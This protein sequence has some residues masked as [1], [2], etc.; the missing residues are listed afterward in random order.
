MDLRIYIF[1]KQVPFR[2]FGVLVSFDANNPVGFL[3]MWKYLPLPKLLELC[4]IVYQ[5]WLGAG[6]HEQF[7]NLS[8]G[9]FHY[10]RVWNECKVCI[11]L[12]L[13]NT[14]HHPLLWELCTL[15][16]MYTSWH[17]CPCKNLIF[18]YRMKFD[19]TKWSCPWNS[20]KNSTQNS[21]DV[22]SRQM[23]SFDRPSCQETL[24]TSFDNSVMVRVWYKNK[25]NVK[26]DFIYKP[27]N[28][29]HLGYSGSH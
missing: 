18:V 19:K 27:R 14:F 13:I 24:A 1:A 8:P 15:G 21:A 22:T 23:T 12:D 6:I 2:V 29:C 20:A 16:I 17:K 28:V 5:Q 25:A 3:Q 4:E 11:W 9:C 10:S 7:H 26:P